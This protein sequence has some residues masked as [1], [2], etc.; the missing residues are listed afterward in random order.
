MEGSQI[1]YLIKLEVDHRHLS[2]VGACYR[3]DFVTS[4]FIVTVR[5]SKVTKEFQ[6]S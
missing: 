2:L 6:L 3:V 4:C 1:H 5:H